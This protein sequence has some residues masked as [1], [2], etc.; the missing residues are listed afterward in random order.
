MA[1]F[2]TLDENNK[3]INILV[4]ESKEIAEEVTGS[5]CVEY[6]EENP[7]IIGLGYSDGLFEQPP[8]P[9]VFYEETPKNPV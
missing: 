2:A 4:A 1:Y 8:A 9:E 3:V 6:T 7:A 5:L